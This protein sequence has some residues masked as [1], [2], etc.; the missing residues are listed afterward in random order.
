M[1]GESPLSRSISIYDS[2]YE[3]HNEEFLE[4]KKEKGIKLASQELK[5]RIITNE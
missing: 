3:K 4:G 5:E 2:Y 1:N